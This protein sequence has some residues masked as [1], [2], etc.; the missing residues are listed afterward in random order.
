MVVLA[1]PSPTTAWFLVLAW[2]SIILVLSLV[3][4]NEVAPAG[5]QGWDRLLHAGFYAVLT[6]LLVRALEAGGAA[7]RGAELGALLGALAVGGVIEWLQGRVG[8]SPDVFDWLADGAGAFAAL[9]VRATWLA[10]TE[11][12]P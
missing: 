1:R 4:L 2:T 11:R 3:S 6:V 9:A 10:V 8:R 7:V 12:S 5:L